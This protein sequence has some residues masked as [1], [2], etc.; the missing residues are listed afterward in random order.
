MKCEPLVKMRSICI[1]FGGVE[2][3]K[4][5]DFDLFPREIVGL[6]GDNGAGKSTLI[7]ILSG[8]YPLT[9]GQM[10]IYGKPVNFRSPEE[11]KQMG[12]ETV[13]QDLALVNDRDVPSNIFL[14]REICRKGILRYFRF[15]DKREMAIRSENILRSVDVHIPNIRR[16]V[17]VLSG[18]QK[19][20]V[21][22]A[23]CIYSKPKILILD[24][25]TAAISVSEREKVLK[26]MK[27]IKE[28]G[29]STIF[30]SHTLSEIFAV[31]D[32]I[33]VLRKGELVGTRKPEETSVEE[34]ICLMVG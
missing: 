18:G 26:F 5:V 21:A 7:K 11:A 6:V 19:Q 25:P 16:N 24:E 2:A 20:G 1:R 29:V 9:E 3:L 8:V 23:R 17:S 34:V 27:K 13:Y 32:R 4:K 31:A 15:L 10:W 30:I 28:R 22:I 14:G 33:V 12:I